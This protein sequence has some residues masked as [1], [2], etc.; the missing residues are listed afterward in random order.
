MIKLDDA[1][2]ADEVGGRTATPNLAVTPSKDAW[3]PSSTLQSTGHFGALRTMENFDDLPWN[4]S[5]R[6][7]A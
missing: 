7:L 5:L 1:D 2:N 4:F 6:R 3:R